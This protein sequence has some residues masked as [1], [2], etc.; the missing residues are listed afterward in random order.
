MLRFEP[1]TTQIQNRSCTHFTAISCS[2]N[3]KWY[4]K[5]MGWTSGHVIF[6]GVERGRVMT[7][8]QSRKS[9]QQLRLWP[10]MSWV[11][12]IFVT[13]WTNILCFLISMH[14]VLHFCHRERRWEENCIPGN[15]RFVTV[16]FR[17]NSQHCT[18]ENAASWVC[19]KLFVCWN[20]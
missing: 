14:Q 9:V 6:E 4:K 16:N 5:M 8:F 3:I 13:T 18:E 20:V 2:I 1:W 7:R 19:L 15:Y 12:V 17:S 11:Q 10:G